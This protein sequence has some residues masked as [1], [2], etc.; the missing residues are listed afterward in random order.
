MGVRYG[1][2]HLYAKRG[3]YATFHKITGRRACACSA[4]GDHVCPC[5]G[6]VFEDSRTAL[7]S[8]FYAIYLFVVMLHGVSSKEL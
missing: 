4:C 6:T 1:L 2:R 8:W 5:A 3:K 7:Q